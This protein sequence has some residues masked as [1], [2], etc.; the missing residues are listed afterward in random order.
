MLKNKLKI[1]AFLLTITLLAGCFPTN[2]QSTEGISSPKP[3][4]QNVESVS[5][6]PGRDPDSTFTPGVPNPNITQAN[7]KET[8]CNPKWS[9]S[10]IRPSSSYT[11]N[12]KKQ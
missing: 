4:I 2:K 11:N 7:I 3:D 6:I 8:I 9:T 1:L 5:H 10:S 12:L